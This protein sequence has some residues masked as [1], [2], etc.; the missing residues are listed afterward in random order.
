[1]WARKDYLCAGADIRWTE[2][3]YRYRV[4]WGVLL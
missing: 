3:T 4:H 1:M 2:P